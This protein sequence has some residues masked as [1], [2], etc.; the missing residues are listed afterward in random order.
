MPDR[1][2]TARPR[3]PGRTPGEAARAEA[4][5]YRGIGKSEVARRHRRQRVWLYTARLW[6]APQIA[7]VTGWPL[8]TIED[9][10]AALRKEYGALVSTWDLKKDMEAQLARFDQLCS[11]FHEHI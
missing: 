7:E 3:P 4:A 11:L 6:T 9:D 1:T 5:K 2:A 10:Q 8:K